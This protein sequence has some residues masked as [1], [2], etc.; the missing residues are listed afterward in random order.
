MLRIENLTRRY[1]TLLALDAVSL[2]V[3][4]GEIVG[5]LGPNGAGKSTLLRTAAGL[6]PPDA[7]SV[8]VAGAD[9]WKHPIEAKQRL[10]YA[11]EEPTFYE[12]LSAE[13]Y[14]AFVSGIRGL[15]PAASSARV[16]DLAGALGLGDRLREPVHGFSHGMRKKL[17]FLAAVLHRPAVLLCDEAL[18]GFDAAAALAA[19][20]ELRAL[21]AAGTAILFSSHVTETMERLCDR[22]VLLSRGRIARTLD[23][24][25]WGSPSPGPGPLER[26]L[27]AL[28]PLPTSPES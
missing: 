14:L 15:D 21:R 24:A 18:E 9:L 28:V 1:G 12:E 3:R 17:S 16:R 22:V 4:S 11:A 2:E 7:G 6:Q 26:E 23:R 13:E 10:G 8:H 25:A 19:K 27:L 5:L 20:D